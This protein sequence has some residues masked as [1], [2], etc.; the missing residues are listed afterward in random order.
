MKI[1]RE[2]ITDQIYEVLKKKIVSGEW[3]AGYK[4]P[5]EGELSEMLGVSRMS[6]RVALQKLN[7]MGL[8]ETVMGGGTHVRSF[9]MKPYLVE[10]YRMGIVTDDYVE[11][12]EFLQAVESDCIRLAFE[13]GNFQEGVADLE[14]MYREMEE[15]LAR[16]DLDAFE[17]V[18]LRFHTRIAQMAD[19]RIFLMIYSAF[20][21][22]FYS[23]FRASVEYSF[24]YFGSYKVVLSHHRNIVEGLRAGDLERC[25]LEEE[26]SSEQWRKKDYMKMNSGESDS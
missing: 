5:S 18:D 1:V 6:L 14:V 15:T 20:A 19:N 3:P 11:I 9:S 23:A 4:L 16:D 21:D 17:Q 2:N 12:N 10:L 25:L 22:L 24:R 8:T 26:M 13:K 7:V